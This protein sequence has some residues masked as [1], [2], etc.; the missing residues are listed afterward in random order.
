MR[1]AKLLMINTVILTL[2]SFL[3]RTISVSFNIYL[4][5]II[6]SS[7]MGLFQL[8][9]AVYGLAVTFASA[10]I[11]LGTTRLIT[12]ALSTANQSTRKIIKMCLKYAVAISS[13][14]FIL[15]YLSSDL[16]AEKPYFIV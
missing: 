10:G 13:I 16:I 3:M 14:I 5:N 7:G 9:I 4:T 15:M 12:E 6:G 8:I 2:G 1:N 11:K